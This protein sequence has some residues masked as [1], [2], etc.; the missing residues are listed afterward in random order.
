VEAVPQEEEVQF[1]SSRTIYRDHSSSS[2]APSASRG[3]KRGAG[4]VPVDR[5]SSSNRLDVPSSTLARSTSTTSMQSTATD[6]DDRVHKRRPAMATSSPVLSRD[7]SPRP[8]QRLDTAVIES[9]TAPTQALS[10]SRNRVNVVKAPVEVAVDTKSLP[11]ARPSRNGAEMIR[12]SREDLQSQ[13]PVP[14]PSASNRILLKTRKSPPA[15]DVV[16][17]PAAPELARTK[18]SSREGTLARAGHVE[19]RE[20]EKEIKAEKEKEK[21]VASPP[22]FGARLLSRFGAGELDR[23]VFSRYQLTIQ[24]N[25]YEQ[26]LTRAPAQSVSG[27][28]YDHDDCNV[29]NDP[30]ILRCLCP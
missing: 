12:P 11:P 21:K 17:V 27:C 18:P 4:R 25:R 29:D 8:Y 14:S 19:T 3:V 28:V 24:P 2:S 9:R 20:R 10:L 23:T 13:I 16:V 30:M 6:I 7:V 26:R 1:V 5:T 15:E 22:R